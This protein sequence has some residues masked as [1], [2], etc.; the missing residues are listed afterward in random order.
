MDKN[1]MS[2][3]YEI[4]TAL[5]KQ[6]REKNKKLL[7]ENQEMKLS[8]TKLQEVE[9]LK[10]AKEENKKMKAR[11][12]LM[13][14]KYQEKL[15]ELHEKLKDLQE[16]PLSSDLVTNYRRVSNLFE[17]EKDKANKLEE[18]KE[19]MKSSLPHLYQFQLEAKREKEENKQ[20]KAEMN[21]MKIKLDQLQSLVDWQDR[22]E[23]YGL[24]IFQPK[25]HQLPDRNMELEEDSFMLEPL[26]EEQP[27]LQEEQPKLQQEQ[28]RKVSTFSLVFDGSPEDLA[29][30][31]VF[32]MRDKKKV[33]DEHIV[34]ERLIKKVRFV[35]EKE[36]KEK[37]V[38]TTTKEKE[39]NTKEKESI[40]VKKPLQ[41]ELNMPSK[42]PAA[43]IIAISSHLEQ[44]NISTT[45]EAKERGR[46]D[47]KIKPANQ[48][49]DK[50]DDG[51]NR[52]EKPKKRVADEHIVNERHAIRKI[53]FVDDKNEKEKDVSTATKEKEGNTKEKESI[54]VKKP[55]QK[56]L[57]MPSKVPAAPIITIS[58][59]LEQQNIS[60][61]KEAKER[62]RTDIK[63][64]PANQQSDKNDGKIQKETP[65]ENK[66]KRSRGKNK[67][68]SER[69][70]RGR[71]NANIEKLKN[72]GRPNA[73]I[74]KLINKEKKRRQE[75]KNK[76]RN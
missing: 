5:L 60:T 13:Q 21:T 14:K 27:K 10:L 22:R 68:R 75:V 17:L 31:E 72:E 47:I 63:I 33:V 24:E 49:S 15:K 38:S 54:P 34:E 16:N 51:G 29:E 66:I 50:N 25:I 40:P 19:V 45:K 8:V 39:G 56:E 59:P 74:K 76:K 11:M 1:P 35:D 64:K 52:K 12:D 32:R 44:Q 71:E 7:E 2:S 9:Q 4:T 53:R 23:M 41:K 6:E 42:V 30:P 57:N 28:P 67:S 62:S 65:K 43:P 61:T 37:E 18:E 46:T 55:L 3:Q 69:K 20:L 48:Q 36:Q 73:E 26:Q 70:K 58:S